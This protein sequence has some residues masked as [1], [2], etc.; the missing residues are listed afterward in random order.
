M[1]E[2]ESAVID[3]GGARLGVAATK[4]FGGGFRGAC[5][6][7]FGETEMKA[8]IGHTRSLSEALERELNNLRHT[9]DYRVALPHYAPVEAT[10]QGEPLE[11]YPFLGSYL[12]AEAIDRAGAELVVHGHAHRGTE[13]VL[14]LAA[15]LCATWLALCSSALTRSTSSTTPLPKSRVATSPRVA[16]YRSA[17]RDAG[18]APRGPRDRPDCRGSQV[19]RCKVS[20]VPCIPAGCRHQPGR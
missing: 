2:G 19:G 8:F 4:G 1:S 18:G 10:L 20:P 5:G 3:A 12:L 9:C 6:S 7:E 11:I 16:G 14:R 15:S 17:F 13:K